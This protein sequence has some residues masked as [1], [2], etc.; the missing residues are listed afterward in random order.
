MVLS[1]HFFT[2]GICPGVCT[3]LAMA[4]PRTDVHASRGDYFVGQIQDECLGVE[5]GVCMV[6]YCF[7]FLT[8]GVGPVVHSILS[9]YAPWYD[10]LATGGDCFVCWVQSECLDVK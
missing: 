3:I 7:I 8:G 10:V 9:I 6:L 4:A 2:G 1:F 5:C